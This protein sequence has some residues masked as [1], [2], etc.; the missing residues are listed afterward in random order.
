[1]EI[2]SKPAIAT[3]SGIWRPASRTAMI[4]PIA[5][6]SFPAKIAAGQVKEYPDPTIASAVQEAVEAFSF[7]VRKLVGVVNEYVVAAGFCSVLRA[8]V[9]S[10]IERI[11]N[12]RN[13]A[14]NGLGPPGSKALGCAVWY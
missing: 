11:G 12:V 7:F 8:A 10:R 3:S 9:E 13:D 5:I 6:M 1:M 14:G 4:A 2:S